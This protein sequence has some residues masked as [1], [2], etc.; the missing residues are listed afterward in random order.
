[1]LLISAG[2]AA[3]ALQMGV[4]VKPGPAFAGREAVL[5]QQNV[6]ILDASA[7]TPQFYDHLLTTFVEMS[8]QAKPKNPTGSPGLIVWPESPA[9]FYASDSK[10]IHWLRTIARDT[11]SYVIV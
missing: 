5:L 11:N 3:V 7:W 2:V 1:S 6:P 10:L 8:V 9:P 4:L